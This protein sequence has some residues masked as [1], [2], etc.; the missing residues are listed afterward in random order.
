MEDPVLAQTARLLQAVN[1]GEIGLWDLRIDLG[2]IYF[3][4]QWKVRL[5][6]PE[7][8]LA[9][10]IHFWRCRV[11]PEDLEGMLSG[12]RAHT[13]GETDRYEARFRFR[14]NG[15]GYRSLHSRGRVLE[16]GEDGRALRL[17]GTSIDL[18]P[19]PSTPGV[20][21]AHGPREPMANGWTGTP[22]HVLLGTALGEQPARTEADRA[23]QLIGDLVQ[24]TL[25][26]L[27]S[28]RSSRPVGTLASWPRR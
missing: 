21:L 5:G 15:S 8:D 2:S 6:L 13:R 19:R 26:Q 24:E 4:P 18:T 10:S 3:S 27:E 28:L 12:M 25:E 23:L 9:E 14:S 16:R 11:H 1:S 20:G 7:P 22:L 17:I